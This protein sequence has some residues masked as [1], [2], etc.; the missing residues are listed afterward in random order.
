MAILECDKCGENVYCTPRSV[1]LPF[2]CADCE[3][4][5]PAT[6]PLNRAFKADLLKVIGSPLVQKKMADEGFEFDY[7]AIVDVMDTDLDTLL[8]SDLQEQ[9]AEANAALVYYRTPFLVKAGRAFA[10]FLDKVLY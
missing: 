2:V 3:N 8:I 1:V 7:S 9:L 6:K 4:A 10:R 5:P